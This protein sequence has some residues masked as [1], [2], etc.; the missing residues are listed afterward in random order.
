MP[1]EIPGREFSEAMLR[2]RR[3]SRWRP[4]RLHVHV[5]SVV[6]LTLWLMSPVQAQQT[7]RPE[8]DP[9]QVQKRIPL[10]S[11]RREPPEPLRLP[12]P[13]EASPPA[14][15]L[16][17]VLAGV[18]L[19]GNTVFDAAALASTYE[20]YLA[21][22]I[23]VSTVAT[24]LQRITA[25]YR[26]QGYF[27]SRAV[28]LP[29]S[30][31]RGIL[32]IKVIEGY[33]ERV[34]FRGA[35]SG[36]ARLRPY[37]DQVTANRPLRLDTL[38]RAIL[39]VNDLPGLHVASSLEP[40]NEQAG[41]YELVLRLDYRPVAGFASLDNRGPESLG[42]WEAQLSA[43]AHS[44]LDSL[45]RAQL[46]F[47]TVPAEPRELL[48]TELFYEHPIGSDGAAAALSVAR[49]DLRPQ[50]NLAPLAL[51]GTAMRYVARLTYPLIRRRE[52][53]L[54][55]GGIFDVFD[56]REHE[57]GAL[58]FDDRLRVLRALV[59][60]S[61]N[62]GLGGANAFYGEASQG[63]TILG[64]SRTGAADLSRSN[65]HPD[66]TKVAVTA[67]RQQALGGDWSVQ[68]GLAGQ[69]AAEPLLT[70]EQFPLGGSRF[71]R[72][73]DPAEV[74]GDDGLAGSLELRYGRSRGNAWLGAY[75]IYGFYDLG[76]VW[77]MAVG[78]ATRRQSLASLGGGVR[79]TLTR[80]VTAAIEVAQPLTRTPAAQG[81]KTARIFGSL[82]ASF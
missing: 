59:N 28:A 78:D 51:K 29:Q 37:L 50:G 71:G 5:P 34:T 14:G 4:G 33:V 53:S 13:P 1:Q 45:D 23:D 46:S 67:T 38:E 32:R 36:E 76:T 44:L 49:S 39:L 47:F 54:W 22:D 69:K 56:S 18:V 70:S 24:I 11:E 77:N 43:S 17:F 81:N 60:Y 72:A 12:T 35:T 68:L 20:D 73:Y 48:S 66:F 3:R 26:D 21:R 16:H 2:R 27:L 55:L 74:T 8:V 10:P 25:K 61:I 82:S 79:V 65:G 75:Q 15:K 52:Q 58:L 62:D 41:A 57:Q 64:A 63:L 9:G 7:I 80:E 40:V 31:D 19:D 42:P 30:I 6:F